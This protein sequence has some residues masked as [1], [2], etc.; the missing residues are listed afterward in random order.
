MVT[1]KREYF[2]S[3]WCGPDIVQIDSSLA[4][5]TAALLNCSIRCANQIGDCTFPINR[6]LKYGTM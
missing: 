4:V 3:P 6:L 2:N 5:M 1:Y